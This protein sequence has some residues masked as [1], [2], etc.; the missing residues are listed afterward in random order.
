MRRLITAS[1]V[2]LALL[3][4]CSSSTKSAVSAAGSSPT[5]DAS[6]GSSPVSDPN[7]SGSAAKPTVN[8]PKDLPTKLVITDLTEGTGDAAKA[9]DE[10]TVNYVGVR[11]AD[12]TEFDNSYDEGRPFTLTLGAGGVITGWD[13]GLVGIKAGGRRQLDIPADLAYGNNP[14]GNII[15]AGDALTFVIDALSITPGVNVPD[16]NP[17]DAPKV[18][19]PTSVGASKVSTTDLITGTGDEATAGSTAYVQISAYR[20]DTAALLQTTW[21]DGKAAKIPLTDTT[22]PG[23]VKGITGMKVGGRRL[24]IVPSE[25]GFGSAGNTQNSLPAV[26]DLVLVV[27]LVAVGAAAK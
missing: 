13:Q 18:S 27:D 15:K 3:A 6:A 11:S 14:Q 1:V 9:G 10:I 19:I 8:V 20:G 24:I 12:G 21:N 23:L 4:G 5:S 25:D 16:A 2:S 22:I 17:A 7:A 26:T